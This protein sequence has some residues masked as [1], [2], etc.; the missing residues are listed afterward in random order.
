MS[1]LFEYQN[2]FKFHGHNTFNEETWEYLID[3][4][5][6]VDKQQY[7]YDYVTDSVQN[8]KNTAFDPP[9]DRVGLSLYA[10]CA[11]QSPKGDAILICCVCC[12]DGVLHCIDIAMASRPELKVCLSGTIPS[13]SSLTQHRSTMRVASSAPFVPYPQS[14]MELV[15]SVSS[16]ERIGTRLMAR[17]Q[18]SLHEQC[19]K[20]LLSSE[21]WAAAKMRFPA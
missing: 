21:T 6:L 16:T 3:H 13:F 4:R 20:P 8:A 17:M 15:Q 18:N 19:T 14:Q 9:R 11:S 2:H 5:W 12:S 1:Q 7:E 10:S